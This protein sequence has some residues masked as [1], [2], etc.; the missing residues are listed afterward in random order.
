VVS[1]CLIKEATTQT[2]F[3]NRQKGVTP[4]DAGESQPSLREAI[5]NSGLDLPRSGRA[6]IP[7][8]GSVS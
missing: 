4:W 7:G 5:E 1:T 3:L 2:R 6:L 8:C